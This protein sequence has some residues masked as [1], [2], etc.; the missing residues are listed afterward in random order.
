M[1]RM[2][3]LWVPVAPSGSSWVQLG[4]SA[5]ASGLALV[6]CAL[7]RERRRSC[8][9]RA[10]GQPLV[11]SPAPHRRPVDYGLSLS[12][13]YGGNDDPADAIAGAADDDDD[14]HQQW[15][16]HFSANRQPGAACATG[17]RS[18]V[19]AIAKLDKNATLCPA[20][21]ADG[22]VGRPA[23]PVCARTLARRFV[24]PAARTRPPDRLHSA[25][26]GAT[27]SPATH[28]IS[29]PPNWLSISV[30]ASGRPSP[31][32]G[33]ESGWLIQVSSITPTGNPTG[34]SLAFQPV[35]SYLALASRP[36]SPPD[37]PPVRAA[38]SSMERRRASQAG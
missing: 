37:R 23:G 31:L 25:P 4:R 16:H 5:C 17:D 21:V 27:G 15:Q 24:R 7:P 10:T 1:S 20:G 33:R 6:L 14:D 26:L 34:R 22:Q 29:A 3:C 30:C 9:S 36:P 35:R 38:D 28:D 18:A 32:A 11:A 8:S 13:Y 19:S 12:D 2:R